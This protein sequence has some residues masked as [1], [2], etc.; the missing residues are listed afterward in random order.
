MVNLLLFNY[1]YN[2]IIDFHTEAMGIKDY[3]KGHGTWIA[4]LKASGLKRIGE[5]TRSGCF[6]T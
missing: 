4:F 3:V 6:P 5:H 1:D 2:I